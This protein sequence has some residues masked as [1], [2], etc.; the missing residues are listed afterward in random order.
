MI[1]GFAIEF[2]FFRKKK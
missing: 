2:Y 1:I